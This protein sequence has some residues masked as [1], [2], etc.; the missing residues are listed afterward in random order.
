VGTQQI[1]GWIVKPPD[2][3]SDAKY[4]LILEIH[5][6]PYASY[7]D[8]F[9]AEIQLYAANGYV[10]LYT[11]PRGST[12]YGTPF[13]HEIHHR[14]PGVDFDDLM[15]GVDAVIDRGYVDVENLFVTGGSGGGVLTAWIVGKTDRFRAAVSAKPVINWYSHTL[16][17]DIGPF[18]WQIDFSGLPWEKPEEYL[19]LSPISYVNNVKTP[20]MLITGEHDYR[21][22]ISEAEQFY[23]ALK[24]QKVDSA[25]VRIPE[26]SHTITARPSNLIRKTAFVLGWFERYRVRP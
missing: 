4:P 18:F 2:F 8:N 11:N 13:V 20:T 1:Q 16:T 14:Y 6:G 24:L 9:S 12:S 22:P 15:S 26:A 17:S 5:G 25:L 21:T 3:H 19:S 10:V 7:G 23:Q